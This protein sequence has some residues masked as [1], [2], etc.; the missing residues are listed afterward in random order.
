MTLE[1]RTHAAKNDDIRE[2]D[3]LKQEVQ[4]MITV[5]FD[6]TFLSASLSTEEVSFGKSVA[7]T[8]SM[9]Y[10]CNLLVK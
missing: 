6:N 4:Y 3:E 2:R 5:P 1:D 7:C 10:L 8:Y 9:Q